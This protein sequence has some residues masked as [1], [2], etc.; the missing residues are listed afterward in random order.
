M[1]NVTIVGGLTPPEQEAD[2]SHLVQDSSFSDHLSDVC[3]VCQIGCSTLPPPEGSH[4]TRADAAFVAPGSPGPPPAG[5][6][7]TV[8]RNQRRARTTGRCAGP[9]T[10]PTQTRQSCL[11]AD[12]PTRRGAAAHLPPSPGPTTRTTVSASRRGPAGPAGS[13]WPVRRL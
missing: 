8:S 11:V 1:F 12:A 3:L 5:G 13:A 4:G 9:D 2:S 7:G 10:T 6:P